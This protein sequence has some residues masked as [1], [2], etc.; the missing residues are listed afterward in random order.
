MKKILLTSTLLS[1]FVLAVAAA[2]AAPDF[3]GTWML[4]KEKSEKLPPQMSNAEMSWVI[5]VAGKAF[6]KE[7]KGGPAAQ[8]ENYHLD[9]KEVAEDTM[10]RQM[11]MKAKRTANLMGEMLELKSVVSGEFNG[12]SFT[13][14]T[15][16]HLELADGGK[17]LKVH[18]V[19]ETPRGTQEA[20][21][22]FT[23]K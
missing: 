15:T 2:V 5:S 21:F 10:V 1:L 12:N 13:I 4:D 9:G 3:S 19:S 23:K 6:K 18:Q 20:K 7:V 11:T 8:T 14:T 22:V 16:Q 17:T